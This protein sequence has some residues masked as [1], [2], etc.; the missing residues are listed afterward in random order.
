[1]DPS[2][3]IPSL[4]RL[5]D[6]LSAN[7]ESLA[8]LRSADARHDIG[9]KTSLALLIGFYRRYLRTL[10]LPDSGRYGDTRANYARV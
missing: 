1:M 10:P 5:L 7:P 9:T 2:P 4:Q 3:P 8:N 6:S